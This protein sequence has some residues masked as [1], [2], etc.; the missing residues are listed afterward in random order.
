MRVSALSMQ[1]SQ[2]LQAAL[3]AMLERVFESPGLSSHVSMDWMSVMQR[4]MQ[5]AMMNPQVMMAAQQKYWGRALEG[6]QRIWAQPAPDMPP[7]DK[8]FMGQWWQESLIFRALQEQYRL[9]SDVMMEE[10]N[11][12]TEG[13]DAKEQA[14][15]R[16]I[17]KQV[18]DALS[19]SNFPLTNPD[20]LQKTW[21][22]NGDNLVEGLD[23]MLKDIQDG[24]TFPL[25]RQ[26][27]EAAFTLG[28]DL[29]TT[30]GRVIFRNDLIELIHY[31]PRQKAV[32][33][34]PLLIFPPWINK[35]YIMDLRPENSFIG[36]MLDQGLDVYLV[37][38]VNPD[39]R[40]KDYGFESYMEQGI[41]A[42]LE[43]VE[44]HHP[45][46]PPHLLGYCIAGTL[47]AMT[48][49]R[50]EAQGQ[51]ERVQSATFLTTLLDFAHA[52]DLT[53]FIT[54]PVL[55]AL[56]THMEAQGYLEGEALKTIFSL[57]RAN[58]LIWPLLVRQYWMGEAPGAFD[59]L[60]WNS[61]STN[62]PAKLHRDYL[63]GC[64]RDNDLIAGRMQV[65]D[66]PIDLSAITTPCY[67]LA[68]EEDHIAPWNAV[69]D[70]AERLKAADV[71]FV[72]GGSGHVAGVINPPHKNKYA[73]QVM[74]QGEKEP[75]S[76]WPHWCEWLLQQ[77]SQ[78]TH[79][80]CTKEGPNLGP[81]PGEYVQQ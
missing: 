1:I 3:S 46:T 50:L 32:H 54:D 35:F 67:F 60:Y 48:L 73:Y 22:T 4:Q 69:R 17:A 43:Q 65:G 51:G 64:Y 12:Q 11:A 70:G 52:G 59:L 36:W 71:T 25:I 72:L 47:L 33:A 7:T 41:L 40:H 61:D 78:K 37:S 57:L 77:G 81:A 28:K 10:V 55:D 16:F 24:Y 56:D 15:I 74:G 13:L 66:T 79:E 31:T 9:T 38:W 6:A 19:P 62:M 18:C 29:A 14:R 58:D 75:G 44:G 68:T 30:K 34:H 42:A 53:L 49:A 23:R 20:V 2:K 63:R 45:D 39:A 76:W 27:E 26:I 21:D 8:R 80:I 5:R